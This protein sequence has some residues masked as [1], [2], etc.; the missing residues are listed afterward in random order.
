MVAT[1]RE[2]TKL[3]VKFRHPPPTYY[4][5]VREQRD[6]LLENLLICCFACKDWPIKCNKVIGRRCEHPS[7]IWDSLG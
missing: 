2:L 5:E 7:A 6:M 1:V 4:T 3:G